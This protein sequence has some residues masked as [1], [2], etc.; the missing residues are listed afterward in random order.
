LRERVPVRELEQVL[1]RAPVPVPGLAPAAVRR[2]T[3]A[4]TNHRLRRTQTGWR[5]TKE[6]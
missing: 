6:R 2:M 1:E 4:G 3:A 5:L